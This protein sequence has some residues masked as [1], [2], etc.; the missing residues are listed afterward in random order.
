MSY[1]T[2]IMIQTSD[3]PSIGLGD[4]HHCDALYKIR[5]GHCFNYL[6][7][8]WKSLIITRFERNFQLQFSSRVQRSTKS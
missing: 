3:V 4:I 8:P 6:C 2:E 5:Q 1:Y 7:E